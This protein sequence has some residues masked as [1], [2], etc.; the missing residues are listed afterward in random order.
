MYKLSFFPFLHIVVKSLGC[1]VLRALI[2]W[3]S[4]C[5][6]S[7]VKLLECAKVFMSYAT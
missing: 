3:M 6:L 4:D 7:Y 2:F 1:Y 5:N